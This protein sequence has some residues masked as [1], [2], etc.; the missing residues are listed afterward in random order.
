MECLS[1]ACPFYLPFL[2]STYAIRA[3]IRMTIRAMNTTVETMT[4]TA[5]GSGSVGPPDVYECDGGGG[6]ISPMIIDLLYEMPNN[7]TTM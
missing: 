6:R 1:R 4:S 3:R 5:K 2:F 7:V